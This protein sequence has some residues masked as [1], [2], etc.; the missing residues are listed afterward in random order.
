MKRIYQSILLLIL[1]C[2]SLVSCTKDVHLTKSE[3]EEQNAINEVRKIVGNKGDVFII[4]KAGSSNIKS[5]SLTDTTKIKY[6]T[7]DQLKEFIRRVNS[8][9]IIIGITDSTEK[10][11]NTIKSNSI[12]TYIKKMDD[13]SL[14]NNG[15]YQCSFSYYGISTINLYYSLDQRNQVINPSMQLNGI[16][17][18]GWQTS[19]LSKINFNPSNSISSFSFAGSANLGL[20]IGNYNIGWSSGW[21]LTFWVNGETKGCI[22]AEAN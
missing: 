19:N 13:D 20:N 7:L 15:L 11:E 17:L 9:E 4:G 8:K 3:I 1:V 14:L 16:S 21:T 6:L 22:I 10:S 2:T 5:Q 12:S 18:I